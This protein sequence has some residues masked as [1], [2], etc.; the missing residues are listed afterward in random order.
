MVFSVPLVLT[1]VSCLKTENSIIYSD[2]VSLSV[3]ALP[4]TVTINTPISLPFRATAPNTCWKD[5]EFVHEVQNDSILI[6][7][8]K[9]TFENHGEI[10]VDAL[11]IEDSVFK[12][13]PTTLKS[14]V[15][16][17]YSLDDISGL[18]EVTKDSIFVKAE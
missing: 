11:I 13:T 1:L 18:I 8:A 7:S 10:C 14:L 15:V 3:G 5:I 2:I 12:Y 16:Y 17:V 4:D 9:A 6:Y